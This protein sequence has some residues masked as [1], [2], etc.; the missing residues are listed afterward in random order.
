MREPKNLAEA[1]AE[2]TDQIREIFAELR[3][4]FAKIVEG[5]L[6]VRVVRQENPNEC[7]ATFDDF[8]KQI[9]NELRVF[10]QE[11]KK[12]FSE[13]LREALANY[14]TGVKGPNADFPDRIEEIRN[15][16]NALVNKVTA[17]SPLVEVATTVAVLQ[18]EAWNACSGASNPDWIQGRATD[19]SPR[20]PSAAATR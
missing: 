13:T 7:E 20:V 5:G 17:K 1:Q 4:D 19:G 2:S 14:P 8:F 10:P 16:L 6:L 12:S 11:G 18:M 15:A 3:Q 9:W